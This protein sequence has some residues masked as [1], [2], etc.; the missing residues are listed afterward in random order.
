MGGN[1]GITGLVCHLDGFQSLGYGSDLVQ[2]DEDGVTT[3]KGDSLCQSLGIGYKEVIT[4]QLYLVAQFC[5]QFLPAFPVFL[6]Q[7]IFY[8]N[9]GVFLHQFL[10]MC[11]QF[12][13]GKYGACLRQLV[14]TDLA[15]LPFAGSGI[16][17]NLEV[18]TGLI[19][20]LLHSL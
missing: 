15:G 3:A 13:G 17:S 2:L 19:A 5:G 6:I 20:C 18:L 8:R 7:C 12:F 14:F 16:H 11:D 9:D 4:D 10:P 1:S